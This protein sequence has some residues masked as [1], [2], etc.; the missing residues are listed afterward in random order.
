MWGKYPIDRDELFVMRKWID[1]VSTLTEAAKTGTSRRV[2]YH[3]TLTKNLPSIQ[4]TGLEPR[5][6]SLSVLAGE[7]RPTIFLFPNQS[8]V[9]DALM[10]WLGEYL[11]E[12]EPLSL[13][14]V[15]LPSGIRPKRAELHDEE[16]REPMGYEFKVY[17]AIPPENI[18]VLS[19]NVD[20][21]QFSQ[22]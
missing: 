18:K 20:D 8:T 17:Q 16:T 14:A 2:Y 3:V 9:E 13:L 21:Y 4:Q 7:N 22:E 11:P 1:A 12:N 19:T 6:G 15:T 10:N 5:L